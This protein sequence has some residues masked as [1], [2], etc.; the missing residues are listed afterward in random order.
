MPLTLPLTSVEA[1]SLRGKIRKSVASG[2]SLHRF[3]VS[4]SAPGVRS[5][6]GVYPVFVA[7]CSLGSIPVV[8]NKLESHLLPK[9]ASG[10][11]H[12]VHI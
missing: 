9:E 3:F 7:I 1:V 11:F 6:G 4:Q 2:R 5:G 10:Q 12:V 8:Q